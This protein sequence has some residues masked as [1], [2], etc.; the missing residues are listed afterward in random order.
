MKSAVVTG[1]LLCL[2]NNTLANPLEL[3]THEVIKP[4]IQ[5]KQETISKS[6]AIRSEIYK[7]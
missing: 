2:A 7:G 4:S 3:E 6:K 1:L 5:E